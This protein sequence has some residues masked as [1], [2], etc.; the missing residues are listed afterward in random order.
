MTITSLQISNFRNLTSVQIAPTL[1]GLNIISGD[2]G[3]G[4]TSLL[5]AIFY[6][7]HGKSFRSSLANRM[8]NH[9]ADKFSLFTQVITE[10]DRMVPLGIEREQ[11]GSTRLRVDEKDAN[12]MSKLAEYLPI[13]MINSQSHQILEAG[14]VFRRKY[15][16]WGLF[17]YSSDFITCWRQYERVLKQRNAILREKRPKREL[18]V[19]TNEL[20]K[21]GHE[22]DQLRKSY[23]AKLQPHL[24]HLTQALLSISDLTVEYDS[25]WPRNTDFAE[26][27]MAAMP[28]DYRIGYTQSGPHRAD[29]EMLSGGL[30]LRHIL[31][32]GQQ[33]LL[34]CAMILAQGMMLAE[35]ERSGLIYLVDDLPSELD[36]FSRQK[37][38]S[39]LAMQKSQIFITAIEK[40]AVFELVSDKARVPTKVFHVEHGKVVELGVQ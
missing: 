2:N 37:L 24:C 12:S 23:I 25:G 26:G 7:G 18:E 29:F 32:R 38:V 3:S 30:V 21:Y 1:Q 4:K 17:Y 8:I 22:L 33:K 6:L 10:L 34:I 28:E 35:Q 13:R 11:S 19:W 39:L 36:L 15:L 31:S 5:E 14:P 27:L 9:H 20:I 16:D 40:E